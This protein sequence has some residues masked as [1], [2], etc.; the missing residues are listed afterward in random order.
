MNTLNETG[1]CFVTLNDGTRVDCLVAAKD[2][3]GDWTLLS[4]EGDALEY[5]GG[6]IQE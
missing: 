4:L 2:D 5:P 6:L 3:Q 1:E